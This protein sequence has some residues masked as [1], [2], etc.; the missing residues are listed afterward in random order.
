M[1]GSWFIGS[2][3]FAHY[4]IA[5]I[6]GLLIGVIIFEAFEPLL[7]LIELAIPFPGDIAFDV[8][9]LIV[10]LFAASSFTCIIARLLAML[11]T[12]ICFEMR[13]NVLFYLFIIGICGFVIVFLVSAVFP[14]V[15]PEEGLIIAAGISAL[16]V[17]LCTTLAAWLYVRYR[18]ALNPKGRVFDR[19][20]GLAWSHMSDP[21]RARFG[22]DKRG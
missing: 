1:R 22:F 14:P 7:F 5:F 16:G 4:T 15:F 9:V 2:L 17:L 13:G 19:D 3:L 20:I 21:R 8:V 12:Y 10:L 11:I 18:W 6:C